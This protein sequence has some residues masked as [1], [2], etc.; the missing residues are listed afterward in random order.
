MSTM[1]FSLDEIFEIYLLLLNFSISLLNFEATKADLFIPHAMLFTSPEIYISGVI[2][3][4][5]AMLIIIL[6]FSL[7]VQ[8]HLH[9]GKQQRPTNCCHIPSQSCKQGKIQGRMMIK[10][11]LSSVEQG[12]KNFTIKIKT[13]DLLLLISI[14]RE[15]WNLRPCTRFYISGSEVFCIDM[16]TNQ[17]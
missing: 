15:Y 3:S 9:H 16:S 17:F 13:V 10:S 2:V 8:G 6:T 1:K 7:F 5:R 14:S 4:R 11:F 12:K